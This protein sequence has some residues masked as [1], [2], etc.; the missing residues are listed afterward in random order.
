MSSYVDYEP[1]VRHRP[2]VPVPYIVW[3]VILVVASVVAVL[4]LAVTED[5]PSVFW[6]DFG[7]QCAI[8]VLA[9]LTLYAS[10][11]LR[12]PNL[13]V[14][15]IAGLGTAVAARVADNDSSGLVFMAVAVFVG[16]FVG[17][18]L[19]V[20]VVGLR[21]PS[22]AATI[23]MT[24]L[25]LGV[26]F[27]LD[28]GGSGVQI[29]PG[30]RW[31][32][33]RGIIVFFFAAVLA[34][35]VAIAML[36]VRTTDG[37]TDEVRR[38]GSTMVLQALVLVSTSGLAGLVGALIVLRQSFVP[39][40]NVSD[41]TRSLAVVLLCGISLRGRGAGVFALIAAAVVVE[42]T[43]FWMLLHDFD[44][45]DQLVLV[46]VLALVGLVVGGVLELTDPA[47]RPSAPIARPAPPP[48][49]A[50]F[51]PTEPSSPPT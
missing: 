11:R 35:G 36:F 32:V 41:L 37:G 44:Y 47:P 51:T 29:D 28:G 38:D 16:L 39:S 8:S 1:V 19:A 5:L 46:G 6:D 30:G 42:T 22:W 13:A 23:G 24:G 34:V 15:G 45:A 50:G 21:I 49:P 27:E 12:V 18:A 9:G 43:T 40:G 20:L 3:D 26:S 48:P 2:H 7:L 31:V 33:D 10:I 4:G 14:A 25:L 17:V